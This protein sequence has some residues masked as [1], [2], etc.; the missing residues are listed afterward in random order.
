MKGIGDNPIIKIAK[1][2]TFSVALNYLVKS[3]AQGFPW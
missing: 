2:F 1:K 3:I